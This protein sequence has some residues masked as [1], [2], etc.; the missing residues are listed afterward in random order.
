MKKGHFLQSKIDALKMKKM[1]ILIPL[2]N[3]QNDQYLQNISEM[4][5]LRI[6]P[7]T[8]ETWNR[9]VWS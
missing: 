1:Y 9:P 6:Q 7:R 2:Q 5:I 3:S 8:R 4:P